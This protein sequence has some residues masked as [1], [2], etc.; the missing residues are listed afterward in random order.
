MSDDNMRTREAR[1]RVSIVKLD[2]KGNYSISPWVDMGI[3]IR[4]LP[5]ITLKISETDDE[6]LFNA[7]VEAMKYCRMPT[8]EEDNEYDKTNESE[9]IFDDYGFKKIAGFGVMR[10]FR[11]GTPN[12]HLSYTNDNQFDFM[13]QVHRTMQVGHL[14]CN[15]DCPIAEKAKILR[16]A[17]NRSVV[18]K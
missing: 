1:R 10:F 9:V 15:V 17:L 7:A 2:E 14:Y 4:T 3:G 8:L 18:F 13:Y 16:E 11:K 5:L 12:T 6:A